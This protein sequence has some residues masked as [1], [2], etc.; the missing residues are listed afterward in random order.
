MGSRGWSTLVRLAVAAAARIYFDVSYG[1]L[2]GSAAGR[3]FL[4]LASVGSVP[5]HSY[6][7][8]ED[9]EVLLEVLHPHPEDRL[10]DLGCG[11]GGIALEVHRRTGAE[12]VGID[13]SPRAIA[14]ATRRAERLAVGAPVSFVLGDLA[15]PPDVGATR[16]YA[17][18]SLMFQADT[19]AAL[20][21]IAGTVGAGGRLFATLVV[22]GS[23]G[24]A[25][26]ART[27]RTVDADI[28][29]MDDVTVALEARSLHR[30]RMARGLLRDTASPMGMLAMGLVL[31]E[32][33]LLRA[34]VSRR[35]VGRWRIA[36]RYR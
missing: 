9:L 21:A 8:D 36:I 12:I 35:Q 3:R 34:L 26:L 15:Q 22:V 6:L 24:R 14:T 1:V 11:V 31:T 4:E 17:I 13:I 32:E 27:L 7:T 18:D 29:R 20:R 25:S 2:T 23:N 10:L 5:V 33:A 19:G 28:E 16:A 30:S